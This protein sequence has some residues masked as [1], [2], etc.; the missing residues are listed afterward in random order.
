MELLEL[1]RFFWD[2]PCNCD[3]WCHGVNLRKVM[4]GW[5]DGLYDLL[6]FLVQLQQKI[7]WLDDQQSIRN[8]ASDMQSWKRKTQ[9]LVICELLTPKYCKMYLDWRSWEI[10]LYLPVLS[11]W[12]DWSAARSQSPNPIKP[13]ETLSERTT[14]ELQLCCHLKEWDPEIYKIVQLQ[15]V[16]VRCK[17][18]W[19][20][21]NGLQ[22]W[23]CS[24]FVNGLCVE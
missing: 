21:S 7:R 11:V 9:F 17:T 24:L 23:T 12:P 22:Q 20:C 3:W 10:D 15:S 5:M 6:K 8:L 16:I 18:H 14:H 13:Q 1:I 2:I 4:D 19:S